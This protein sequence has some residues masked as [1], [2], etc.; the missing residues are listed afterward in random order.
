MKQH[1]ANL[2]LLL[3]LE[4]NAALKDGTLDNYF[5]SVVENSGQDLI[6]LTCDMEGAKD[7]DMHME[8]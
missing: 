1:L 6:D 3:C 7:G 2:G 8:E 5:R 4:R